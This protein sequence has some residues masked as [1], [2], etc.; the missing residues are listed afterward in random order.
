MGKREKEHRR[1]VQKRRE[2]LKA[3]ENSIMKMRM[4]FFEEIQKQQMENNPQTQNEP[5][6]KEDNPY[7]IQGPEI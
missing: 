2:N 4:K 7:Q 6:K 5:S 3:Q 1:K